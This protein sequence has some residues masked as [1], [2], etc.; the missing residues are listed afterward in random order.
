MKMS[1]FWSISYQIRTKYIG[2]FKSP[3]A[4]TNKGKAEK[5]TPDACAIFFSCSTFIIG[6]RQKAKT[7]FDLFPC[8]ELSSTKPC[9]IHEI[10]TF[11]LDIN[12]PHF[13][14]ATMYTHSSS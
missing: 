8:Q 1:C 10:Q 6:K 13:D 12:Q 14:V 11:L 4:R 9:N 2:K 7:P 3:N 5:I